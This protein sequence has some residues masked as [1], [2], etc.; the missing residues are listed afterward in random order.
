MNPDLHPLLSYVQCQ[1]EQVLPVVRDWLSHVYA[2]ADVAQAYA[3]RAQLPPGGWFVTPGGHLVGA[4]SVL[5]HAP[6]S[7]LHG[8]LARQREIER[9]ELELVEQN[10]NAE[11]SRVQVAQAEQHYQSI[12]AQ[13][14]PLRSAG[15]HPSAQAK[16]S[17]RS[18]G[19]A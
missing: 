13:I 14:A 15:P 8:V 17:P 6:D 11:Y 7:Q 2:V 4:H 5:F 9:L 1:D 10:R 12:E 19:A 18:S 3:Q 16:R